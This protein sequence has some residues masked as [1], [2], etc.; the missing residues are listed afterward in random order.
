[1][2]GISARTLG[3]PYS[4]IDT[5]RVSY[6]KSSV[7]H[8]T[9][10]PLYPKTRE[11]MALFSSVPVGT[12]FNP[13]ILPESVRLP[14]LAEVTLNFPSRLNA[15]AIDPSKIA[16]NA[17]MV[18]T[19]GE[20]LFSVKLFHTVNVKIISPRGILKISERTSRKSLVNHAVIL[21]RQATGVDDGLLVDVQSQVDFRHAGFGTSSALIAAVAAAVNEVYGCPIQ[22][23]Q[24]V[25]YLAQ[26]HGEEIDGNDILIQQ[27]QCIGG[28]AISGLFPGGLMIVAGKSQL[29]KAMFIDSDYSVVI[30][31]PKDYA[32]RDAKELMRL[33][34]D[35]LHRFEKTGRQYG[36]EIAYR[37][38]HEVLPSLQQGSLK[39]IG[40]LIFDYRFKMGSIENCSFVFPEIIRISEEL[41]FLKYAGIV[42]VLSLSSVGPSFFAVTR[43]PAPCLEAFRNSGLEPI[44]CDIENSTYSVI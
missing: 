13:I 24:L 20:I 34:E 41:S 43:H 12:I 31:I 16:L 44:Q 39:E 2:D 38:I 26:N 40:D 32:P 21:F 18:F 3:H 28:S 22:F 10:L 30:G 15:M 19:P 42:D 6:Q 29:I 23:D 9:L 25:S 7:S 37:L 14:Q 4:H 5:R 27:V 35:N 11:E 17:N 33:E 8:S 1:M 36:R